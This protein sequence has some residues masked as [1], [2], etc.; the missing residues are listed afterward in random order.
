M[1]LYNY[2]Y[3]VVHFFLVLMNINYCMPGKENIFRFWYN[4]IFYCKNDLSSLRSS[5]IK[6]KA[7]R[8]LHVVL[9]FF[10][11]ALGRIYLMV[12]FLFSLIWR[13]TSDLMSFVFL[14][15]HSTFI[16]E[17]ERFHSISNVTQSGCNITFDFWVDL[18]EVSASTLCAHIDIFICDYRYTRQNKV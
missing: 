3:G 6:R 14:V 12:L 2:T 5:E 15:L 4:A 10:F 9:L 1:C 7:Q 17:I 8:H 11:F 13:V 16:Y 18:Q